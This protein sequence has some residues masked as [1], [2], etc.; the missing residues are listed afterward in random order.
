MH[1]AAA[2]GGTIKLATLHAARYQA[3]KSCKLQC[4]TKPEMTF[5]ISSL[6]A[7]V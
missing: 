2:H 3:Q 4:K 7:H 6:A 5:I 1:D